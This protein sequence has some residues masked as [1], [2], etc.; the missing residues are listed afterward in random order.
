M[1][2]A[3]KVKYPEPILAE[4]EREDI[5]GKIAKPTVAAST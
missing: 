5:R 3:E 4:S 1:G 2:V